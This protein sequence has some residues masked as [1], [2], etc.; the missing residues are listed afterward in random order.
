MY[1]LLAAAALAASMGGLGQTD[2]RIICHGGFAPNIHNGRLVTPP[3]EDESRVYTPGYSANHA[4]VWVGDDVKDIASRRAWRENPGRVAYGAV[5]GCDTERV[6]LRVYNQVVTISPW[7][8]FGGETFKNFEAGRQQWLKERGY[9]G[10][11]RTFVNP[12]RLRA[13]QAECGSACE[14]DSGKASGGLPEPGGTIKKVDAGVAGGL[15]IVSGSQPV[16]L[17]FPMTTNTQIVQRADARGWTESEETENR[18]TAS[19]E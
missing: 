3:P 4:R 7:Q 15:K 14:A 17:S 8:H 10:G 18:Q 13:M 6:N 9:T 1:T 5:D 16:R 11:V 19:K 12:A 2:H